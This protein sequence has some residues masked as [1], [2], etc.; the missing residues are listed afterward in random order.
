MLVM[1]HVGVK[2]ISHKGI[3]VSSVCL[4]KKHRKL[5]PK[6]VVKDYF[7]CKVKHP[8]VGNA[9]IIVVYIYLIHIDYDAF[10]NLII[11][12]YFSHRT[13]ATV[14]AQNGCCSRSESIWAV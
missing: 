11:I 7:R 10:F 8:K 2:M 5:H 6:M 12:Y 14:M 3:S 13:P 9:R 4:L 1:I